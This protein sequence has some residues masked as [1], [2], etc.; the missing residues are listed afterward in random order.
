MASLCDLGLS[1]YEERAYTALLTLRAATAE[2]ISEESGVPK[3]RIYDVVNGLESRGLVRVQPNTRP[4]IHRPINPEIAVTRLLEERKEEL[5]VERAR[6]ESIA[7]EVT[8]QLGSKKPIDGRFWTAMGEPG[9]IFRM[10]TERV[11]KATDEWK[12]TGTTVAG[13]LFGLDQVHEENVGQFV[14]ALD[15]GITVKVLLTR[16]LLR[17]LPTSLEDVAVREITDHKGFELRITDGVYNSIDL[18]DQTDLCVYVADPFDPHSILGVTQIDDQEF[19]RTVDTSFESYW[20]QATP[21]T[22]IEDSGNS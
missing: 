4:R 16:Q 17:E 8:S 19:V 13:G 6:Y 2:E 7:A 9:E 10:L 18:I 12:L 22:S 21:I 1:S 3:G 20:E 11:G 14:D 15:Q 5:T